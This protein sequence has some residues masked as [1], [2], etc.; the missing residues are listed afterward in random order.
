MMA[1]RRTGLPEGDGDT[2]NAHGASACEVS[3]EAAFQAPCGLL[4]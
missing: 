4:S 1:T 2:L 3:A